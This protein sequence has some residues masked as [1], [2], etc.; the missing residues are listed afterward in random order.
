MQCLP[1]S[2]D[3]GGTRASSH[4]KANALN[5]E[6]V[7]TRRTCDGAMAFPNHCSQQAAAN[8][9]GHIQRQEN[10]VAGMSQL[11][12]FAASA[13]RQ[14]ED[15]D[16]AD[17]KKQILKTQPPYAGY[18]DSLIMFVVQRAGGAEGEDLQNLINFWRMTVNPKLRSSLPQPVYDA[19]AACKF[20]L[21]ALSLWEAAYACPQ[22]ERHEWSVLV[23]SGL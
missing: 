11:W 22:G 20:P 18:L 9:A 10:E 23:A 17:I 15:P 6:R 1:P 3:L 7:L 12:R 19:L 16:W 2:L 4:W 13:F 21:L 8:V 14:G 5:A